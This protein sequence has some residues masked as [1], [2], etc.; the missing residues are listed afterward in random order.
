MGDEEPAGA[1]NPGPTGVHPASLAR[2]VAFEEVP[3]GHARGIED[4]LA[5]Y[6][7]SRHG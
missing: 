6:E 5:Q 4:P 7:A 2:P 3:A 1:Q